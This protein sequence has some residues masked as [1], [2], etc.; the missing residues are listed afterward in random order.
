MLSIKKSWKVEFFFR[1]IK[2]KTAF[3]KALIN[4]L[5]TQQFHFTAF[6]IAPSNWKN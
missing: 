5:K 3:V 4:T 1:F 6:M 2:N